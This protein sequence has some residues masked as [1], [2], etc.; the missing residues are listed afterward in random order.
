[1]YLFFFGTFIKICDELQVDVEDTIEKSTPK[2]AE[3]DMSQEK[4]EE[5]CSEVIPSAEGQP[6]E[7]HSAGVQPEETPQAE[8]QP[9]EIHSAE[10]QP[11]EIQPE[12]KQ[13][14]DEP[15]LDVR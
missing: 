14:E 13:D 12:E 4:M 8:M 5:N 2:E 7:V 6:P 1:M 9:G 11:E 3:S 15:V 10:V